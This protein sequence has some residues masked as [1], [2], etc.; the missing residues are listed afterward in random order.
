[1]L[2][3]NLPKF[4]LDARNVAGTEGWF[5]DNYLPYVRPAKLGRWLTPTSPLL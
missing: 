4:R 3:V 5:P 2:P 1:M